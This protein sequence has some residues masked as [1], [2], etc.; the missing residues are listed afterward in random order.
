MV[1]IC[2]KASPLPIAAVSVSDIF[3]AD[4]ERLQLEPIA[5]GHFQTS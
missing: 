3:A 4:I 1:G 2:D 5:K